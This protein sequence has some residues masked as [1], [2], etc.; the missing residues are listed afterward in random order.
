[1]LLRRMLIVI[2]DSLTFDI[3]RVMQ[4]V[5]DDIEYRLAKSALE[6]KRKTKITSK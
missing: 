6:S 2:I 4:A 3:A 1:M 5:L